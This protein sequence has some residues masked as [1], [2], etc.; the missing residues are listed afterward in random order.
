MV[1]FD[2]EGKDIGVSDPDG[3]DEDAKSKCVSE[4]GLEGEDNDTDRDDDDDDAVS[5]LYPSCYL[6]DCS[7][8]R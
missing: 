8:N 5:F 2:E 4:E 3:G 6:S 7:V 1:R